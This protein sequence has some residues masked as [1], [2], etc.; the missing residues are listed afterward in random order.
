MERPLSSFIGS[1]LQNCDSAIRNCKCEAGISQLILMGRILITAIGDG[2]TSVVLLAGEYL[3][4]LKPYADEGVHPRVM[5]KA[6]RKATQ[7]ALER[8]NALSVK[9][10]KSNPA[11]TRSLLEK[12]ASTALSSKLIHQQKDF[13]SKMVVDA[14]LQ[15]DELLP[16]DMIG[17][18]K[19]QG[20]ALEVSKV[21]SRYNF[22]T[23]CPQA[24]TVTLVLRGGAE[25]FL[26]ES[27]RSL[28]DAIMIVRRTMK[29]DAVVAGGGAIEM[30][31]SKALRDHS[32]TVAGKE[33][34]LIGA[35]AK[36]LEVIPKQLCDNAGFD[37]TSILNKLRQRH[38]QGID[39]IN[40]KYRE[41]AEN[42]CYPKIAG[43]CWYGVD[44]MTED[45]SDNMENCVWEPAMVKRNALQAAGEAVC[46]I[47]SVDETIK[48]PK[49]GGD[50]MADQ[51]VRRPILIC[52]RFLSQS[53]TWEN[54]QSY[55]KF[56]I[57]DGPSIPDP[58]A[59]ASSAAIQSTHPG[60]PIHDLSPIFQKRRK[61]NTSE[62]G[63]NGFTP[64][65]TLWAHT[66][67]AISVWAWTSQSVTSTSILTEEKISRDAIRA[68]R[69]TLP[70]RMEV[71]SKRVLGEFRKILGE[72][73]GFRENPEDS[74]RSQ[75]VPGESRGFQ[76]N[77]DESWGIQMSPGES[78]GFLEN[79][80]DS[81]R[82]QRIP[83]ES[84]GFQENP[85][86]SRR[87]Q[88]FPG[89]SRGFKENPE[90]SRRIQRVQEESGGSQENPVDSR[91]IQRI[92]GESTAFLENPKDSQKNPEVP[93][94]FQRFPEESRCSQ[95]NPE[96]PRRIRMIPGGS[97]GFQENQENPNGRICAKLGYYSVRMAKEDGAE[98]G[99]F[100][101]HPDRS[102]VKMF[103][104]TNSKQP[105]C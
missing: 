85:E 6:V 25:Q 46:L 3:K 55:R 43:S 104:I 75:R 92:P 52:K 17:I 38:A 7:L 80:E 74:R 102:L 4:Q 86:D 8:I 73:R 34:L 51:P 76:D 1:E 68:S 57:E 67:L 61:K 44:V 79:P 11:E 100:H 98:V 19:V 72:S 24:K 66:F 39:G 22:F 82:I 101:P 30:E 50:S 36:A 47:I 77:S 20:G 70:R 15:L 13:F 28:H 14:V 83:G 65:A 10:D 71:S 59:M 35:I 32:R 58:S 5:I 27:E 62:C 45:I 12:C 99:Q 81:R 88:R 103:T 2:T 93:R 49:S 94:R 96:V 56:A 33:Q 53:V 64:L 40:A 41:I 54:V 37:A 23:G 84:R 9:I 89:E 78:R 31:L 60:S 105:Y 16:L 69:N 29:H 18:K 42:H 63:R 87:I 97:R 26:E 91:R 95:E 90:G 48:N 21:L